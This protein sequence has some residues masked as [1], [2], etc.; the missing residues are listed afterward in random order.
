MRGFPP[1]PSPGGDEGEQSG[2]A[3]PAVCPLLAWGHHRVLPC[4]PLPVPGKGPQHSPAPKPAP[5]PPT[6]APV[7]NGTVSAPTS[8]SSHPAPA[9]AVGLE[10]TDQRS[11]RL[12]V[13]RALSTGCHPGP[14]HSEGSGDAHLWAGGPSRS[15][16]QPPPHT[17]R[18]AAT[19]SWMSPCA[20]LLLQVSWVPPQ[21]PALSPRYPQLPR[22]P[23]LEKSL[24]L[25]LP[26]PG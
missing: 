19:Q 10:V 13:A 5:K 6:P 18:V 15:L 3:S 22:S 20:L 24:L 26:L 14:S 8:A 17:I 11:P 9:H 16:A 7:S 4:H 23:Y 2:A 25:G 12:Y 21:G 1:A